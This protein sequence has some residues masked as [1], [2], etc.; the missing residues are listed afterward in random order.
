MLYVESKTSY[1]SNDICI[2]LSSMAKNWF[3]LYPQEGPE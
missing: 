1:S 2:N 3:R